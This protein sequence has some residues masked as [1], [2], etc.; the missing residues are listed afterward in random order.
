[1][2]YTWFDSSGFPFF[3]H[4]SGQPVRSVGAT[5]VMVFIANQFSHGALFDVLEVFDMN[6]SAVSNN[7]HNWWFSSAVLLYRTMVSV[8]VVALIIASA[9]FFYVTATFRRKINAEIQRFR[10]ED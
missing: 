2:N 4:V 1:A 7:P 3:D 8:F 10:H 9:Q 5:P 6:F